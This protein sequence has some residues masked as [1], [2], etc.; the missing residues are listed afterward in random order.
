MNFEK[1]TIEEYAGLLASKKSTPGGGSSLALVLINAISLCQMVFNF[2]KDKGGYEEYRNE[3]IEINEKLEVLLKEAYYLLNE[4][5]KSFLRLMEAYKSKD[6]K[7]IENT[8]IEACEVPYRLFLA[9]KEVENYASRLAYIGNKNVVSD[10]RIAEDLCKSI[11]N[12]CRLN[13]S[14]NIKSIKKEELINKYSSIL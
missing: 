9:T 2:T 12:G 4:D 7:M 5:S 1:M 8:S 14:A 13:I 6:E 11:Y 3:V 10:A